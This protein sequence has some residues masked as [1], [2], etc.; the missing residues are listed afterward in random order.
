MDKPEHGY[1]LEYGYV[2]ECQGVQWTVRQVGSSDYLS[3]HASKK[4]AREAAK[5]YQE[6]DKR[7][8]KGKRL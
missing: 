4:E 5:R 8:A 3:H 1:L 7:R 2:I 6:A